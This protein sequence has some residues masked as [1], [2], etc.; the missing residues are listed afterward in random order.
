[1]IDD[2]CKTEPREP[3][4]REAA[5]D[6]FVR[7]N[8]FPHIAFD[9][10]D[11]QR[12]WIYE[13]AEAYSAELRANLDELQMR[14]SLAKRGWAIEMEKARAAEASLLQAREALKGIEILSA[15]CIRIGHNKECA[16]LEEINFLASTS[17]P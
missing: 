9:F 8:G 6:F 12:E 5:K 10:N 4:A 13:F 2:G 16:N 7:S 17:A 1:M 11:Q 3:A 14:E 15:A